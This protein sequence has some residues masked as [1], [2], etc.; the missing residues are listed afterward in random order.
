MQYTGCMI[1]DGLRMGK[2]RRGS[3]SALLVFL[4]RFCLLDAQAASPAPD[5]EVVVE[6]L[7]RRYA[8]VDSLTGD[9]QQTY[10]APGIEQ[11]ESGV[12]WL[13]KPGFMRWECRRPEEKLFVADG[14]ESFHYVSQDRQVYVQPFSASDLYSTPLEFLLGAKNIRES[15]TVSWET[16]FKPKSGHTYL[17]R[18]T[19][20]RPDAV[21]SFLVLELDQ[22][23]WDIR[24]L[25]IRESGG[26][27]SEFLFT[28]VATDVKIENSKFRFK[29]PKGVEV[30]RLADKQ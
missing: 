7:Q 2:I 20:R 27:T 25:L 14:K 11:V 21:Y 17:I 16:E 24:R 10:R 19:P 28:D 4:L 5:L 29:P 12:F 6:G 9:F 3:S 13:K 15:F 23:T 8:S 30:I 18:L 26:N 22:E 1:H